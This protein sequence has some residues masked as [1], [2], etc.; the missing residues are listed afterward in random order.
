M[1]DL[2]EAAA[3]V[4]AC[5]MA[6]LTCWRMDCPIC[7]RRTAQDADSTEV[8]AAFVTVVEPD[9][10]TLDVK[11]AA[12]VVVA[13]DVASELPSLAILFRQC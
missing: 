4:V 10:V 6:S 2:P 3:L 7:G 1:R 12:V 8:R 11:S 5:W 9:V 13:D